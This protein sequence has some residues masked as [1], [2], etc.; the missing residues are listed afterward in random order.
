MTVF[1][2]V[3]KLTLDSSEYENDLKKQSE[4]GGKLAGVWGKIGGAVKVGAAAIGAA[5][6]AV[7][8]LTKKSVDAYAEFEQLKGGVE[9]L[10]GSAADE[11]MGYANDAYRTAG[12]SANQYMEQATS[13]SAALIN[14]LGG[15][16]SKAAKQTDVAMRAISDNFNT[17]GGDITNVQNAFQGFAK[18]NFSMLDNLK[19]GYGGT[20]GEMARLVD[21]ANEYAKSIGMAG[22]LSMDSFSD[23]VTAI[24]LI[25]QKQGIAGTTA[26]EAATTIE[27]SLNMTKAAWD[28]L[29][30]GLADPNA[31]I[32]QLID[33]LV[34]AIVGDKEGTGLLNNIIPA[35]QRAVE[36]IGKLLQ[37]AIP[38]LAQKLPSLI[39]SFLPVV[40][41]S[42]TTLVTSLI[43]ELPNVLNALVEIAPDLIELIINGLIDALAK[44]I[45][46]LIKQ[47][48]KMVKA[49]ASGITRSV[50]VILSAGKRLVQSLGTAISSAMGSLAGKAIGL[51]R[52]IP[53]GIKRGLTSLASAGSDLIAG[54]WGGIKSRFDSIVGRVSALAARLPA[55]VKKVLGIA[56][57]SKV[58]MEIGKWIPEGLALGI[59]KNMGSV[60]DAVDAMS[61]ATTFS[62][63]S[64]TVG[65]GAKMGGD[66]FNINLAYDADADSTDMLR[67]LARGVQRYRMAGAI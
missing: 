33:N 17:F 10:Y 14:S 48:P 29:I 51:A 64:G 40:I 4:S 37:S 67:D 32:G 31:D 66:V 2:L 46:L 15:D 6:V 44:S 5:S 30:T 27:G 12:M 16:Q 28:N 38:A 57:P 61:T 62:P 8:A 18:Q 11:L 9:K 22:D 58:F 53:E 26:K 43:Q 42:A 56:S 19:L 20:K 1:E 54:L 59:E 45:P 65:T 23:I 47:G 36:G 3:A 35:V 7:G 55:A 13:F 24:D 25:Q 63:L 50:N 21:D 34:V 41:Q 49:L 52:K 39:Q 60:Q